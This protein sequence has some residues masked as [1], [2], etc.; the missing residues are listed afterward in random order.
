MATF[1]GPREPEACLLV[2]ALSV[3]DYSLR[4]EDTGWVLNNFIAGKI[5]TCQ[6]LVQGG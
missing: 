2:S 5:F 1:S 3:D 6:R 4:S